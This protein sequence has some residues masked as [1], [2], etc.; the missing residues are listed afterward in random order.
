MECKRIV[1]LMATSGGVALGLSLATQALGETVSATP[2]IA[3]NDASPAPAG[4]AD[5]PASEIV[6]TAQKRE[7]HLKDV[8][9]SLVVLTGASLQAQSADTLE[10]YAARIPGLA[11]NA[12]SPGQQQLTIRGISTGP[13]FSTTVATYIDDAPVGASNS[14]GLGGQVTPEI[15]SIDLSRIEVLRGPQGTLYGASNI[16]G[17]IKYVTVAPDLN[18]IVAAGSLEGLSADHGDDGYAVRGRLSVP[19]IS[20]KVAILASG[21]V[22][23]D[24]GFID[25]DLLKRHNLDDLHAT[26]WRTAVLLKPVDRLTINLAAIGSNKRSD[27]FTQIDV[28]SITNQPLFGDYQQHHARDSDYERTQVRL[29]Y[30]VVAYDL[31]WGQLSST[32]SYNTVNYRASQEATQTFAPLFPDGFGH[33]DLGYAALYNI[34][35]NKLTEEVRLSG[36]VGRSLDWLIGGYY[37]RERSSTAVNFATIDDLTG[38]PV[39]IGTTL[40][41]SL[42]LGR[43]RE[44]A[45]FAQATYHV[46][47]RFDLTG[48][49]RYA[50]NRQH[51]TIISDGL[52]AGGASTVVQKSSG[53]ATTFTVAPS[54]KLTR[55]VRVYARVASGY[56]P[57]GPNTIVAPRLT[58]G[59]DR[60]TN[61]EAGIKGS[62]LG[63]RLSF[64]LDGFYIDWTKIQLQIEQASTGLSYTDN[65][66][67]ASSRGVEAN[68]GYQIMSGFD[69]QLSGAYVD[70][71]L[72]RDI[73]SGA[74]GASGDPLPFS[75]KWK[76][77]ATADYKHSLG[78]T[79]NGFVGAGV[80]Y[81]SGVEGLFQSTADIAR[82]HL[83]GYATVDARTGISH[84][85]L[86]LALIAKN[87]FD[88]RGY[89]GVTVLSDTENSLNII[90]PRTIALELRFNY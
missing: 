26:G 81:S 33:T 73:P 89:N 20:D 60:V 45:G 61:Y 18:N 9:A 7:E 46:T 14:D 49:V 85:P 62:L 57:G 31:G 64:D 43:Y 23:K 76:V 79:L 22:R 87:I 86:T 32:T 44:L 38:V 8:P 67:K 56:R 55:G 12:R 51:D 75:S 24:P 13:G 29:Y 3:L 74:F 71:K 54:Y 1:M 28:D 27:G 40:L 66:G 84:G 30:G 52:L 25:D 17:L 59:P 19:I 35:Q 37:T 50:D 65:V 90:Q 80:F 58:Y 83:P 77:A 82:P 34:D 63:G 21:Y 47:S 16:G 69:V 2:Q 15:D 72:D 10:D 39:D 4:A 88:K 36:R 5:V 41:N 70:A 48:G 78:R 68:V 42:T 6:V 11:L 53:S